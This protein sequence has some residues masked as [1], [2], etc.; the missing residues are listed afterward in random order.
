M[1]SLCEL[2]TGRHFD[3]STHEVVYGVICVN[4][5][6]VGACPTERELFRLPP[7]A[8]QSTHNL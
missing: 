6:H 8:A 2:D 5:D 1:T 7:V 3:P 4:Q